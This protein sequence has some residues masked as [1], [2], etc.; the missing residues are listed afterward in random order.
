[1]GCT[2]RPTIWG[3]ETVP[4]PCAELYMG[5]IDGH[6]TLREALYVAYRPLF[7]RARPAICGISTTFQ[8]AGCS[9]WVISTASRGCAACDMEH[10]DLC[11]GWISWSPTCPL[12]HSP[13]FGVETVC[14]MRDNEQI[15]HILCEFLGLMCGN[16]RFLCN[17]AAFFGTRH[18]EKTKRYARLANGNVRNFY[19]NARTVIAV[20]A[21]SVDWLLHLHYKGYSHS[22]H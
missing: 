13:R 6:S 18:I 5:Y 22:L 2:E 9:I 10:I 12:L 7:R 14:R 16:W 11:R 21:Y 8:R 4:Q 19:C 3:Y 15:H 17:F 1:M 20:R